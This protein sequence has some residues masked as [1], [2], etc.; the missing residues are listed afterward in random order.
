MEIRY[1]KQSI[2][3]LAK[4]EESV[5]LRIRSALENFQRVT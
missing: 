5:R 3:F 4:Q 1:S 2:K